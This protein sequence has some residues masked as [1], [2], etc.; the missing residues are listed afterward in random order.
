MIIIRKI[1]M[2]IVFGIAGCN[3]GNKDNPGKQP[4]YII[5][6]KRI[7]QLLLLHHLYPGLV[8]FHK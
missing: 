7:L 3:A 1:G 4:G 5:T 2:A 6:V 8:D